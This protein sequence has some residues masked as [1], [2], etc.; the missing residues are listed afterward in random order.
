M[1]IYFVA[2]EAEPF[3]KSGGLGDVAAALPRQLA[4]MGYDVRVALPLYSS[5]SHQLRKE[6]K[7][8]YN[9]YVEMPKVHQY[10]GIFTYK[11]QGVKYYFIDNEYYFARNG[12]YGFFDDGERFSFYDRAILDLLV[13]EKFYPDIIHLNDWHTGPAAALF[14]EFYASQEGFEKTRTIFT[15]HNLK[16]QGIFPYSVLKDYLGLGDEYFSYDKMEHF[17]NINFLKAGLSLADYVTTVSQT[18]AAE[19]QYAYY[20]EG[21]HSLILHRADEI[22][23]IVNGI[24]IHYYNPETDPDIFKNFSV[25][26]LD[27]KTKNKTEL[28]KLLGLQEDPDVP[29]LSVI[30]RLT[31]QK[32]LDLLAFIFDELMEER[33]QFVLLGS[34][35]KEIEGQFL[36]FSHRYRGKTS[37]NIFFSESLAKKIYAAADMFLMPSRFEPCGLG[38]LIAMRYATVPIVRKTGGLADTVIPYNRY[39]GEGT[40]F[41][42]QN[43]NAHELLFTIKDALYYY[44]NDPKAW[45]QIMVQAM[46]RDYSWESSAEQYA[47]LFEE[48]T[49]E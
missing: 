38:Q 37:A 2:S 25:E 21:L 24:D 31:A 27:K 40:G 44:K 23:G 13:R 12:L 45:Q 6:F 14:K 28:Q 48:L 35:D 16:Y 49:S 26:Q 33:V 30:S 41:A 8:E 42:F 1:K 36:E 3:A 34:G 32:G 22:R 43:Y 47:R 29:L 5:I 19:L 4:K 39:T 7:Y 20:S 46:K 18:Y 17:G 11:Y 9:F 10:A 15:I